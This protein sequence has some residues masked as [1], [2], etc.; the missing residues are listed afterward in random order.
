[1]ISRGEAEAVVAELR[2][3]AHRS[4]SLVRDYTGLVAEE[5]SAP[6]LIVDRPG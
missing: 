5:R 1:M 4:T 2:A 6:V 3:G